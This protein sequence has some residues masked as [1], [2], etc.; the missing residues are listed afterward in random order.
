MTAT[1]VPTSALH[2]IKMT[3][4]VQVEV[5]GDIYWLHL[6]SREELDS[7]NWEALA[8]QW[9]A[10]KMK[11]D[12]NVAG[13][14][15]AAVVTTHF[16][17]THT[18][19]H[20]TVQSTLAAG[21]PAQEIPRDRVYGIAKDELEN[22]S[23]I[24]KGV[25]SHVGREGADLL[26]TH[27]DRDPSR[28]GLFTDSRS[29]E[30]TR[31]SAPAARSSLS[32]DAP[33]AESD[34][35]FHDIP[36]CIAASLATNDK[37]RS[38]QDIREFLSRQLKDLVSSNNEAE[39]SKLAKF[40]RDDNTLTPTRSRSD[41]TVLLNYAE[42]IVKEGTNPGDT[43][44][45]NLL[46]QFGKKHNPPLPSQI[47]VID[48]S[49][50]LK[51]E[52]IYEEGERRY[53]DPASALVLVQVDRQ[54]VLLP[55][56]DP[57]RHDLW[58]QD[59]LAVAC[60]RDVSIDNE[61]RLGC[62]KRMLRYDPA[63]IGKWLLQEMPITNDREH[64]HLVNLKNGLIAIDQSN[65]EAIIQQLEAVDKKNKQWLDNL[66]KGK[67]DSLLPRVRGVMRAPQP[68]PDSRS[69]SA[70][71]REIRLDRGREEPAEYVQPLVIPADL[72]DAEED[73]HSPLLSRRNSGDGTRHVHFDEPDAALT[74]DL[75]S[76]PRESAK[77]NRNRPDAY[78]GLSA[79]L[80]GEDSDSSRGRG[81][82]ASFSDSDDGSF[83]VKR[84]SPLARKESDAGS[85][86][87]GSGRLNFRNARKDDSSSDEEDSV[88][89][90]DES[91]AA[92]SAND[93]DSSSASSRAARREP[94]LEKKKNA[95]AAKG[96]GKKSAAKSG[97]KPAPATKT[98]TG[99]KRSV[100]RSRLSDI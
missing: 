66:C 34:P 18:V 42:H 16:S 15:G 36:G 57:K 91:D 43:A 40:I 49:F 93:S 27:R 95:S 32:L 62:V 53:L 7:R 83:A 89:S 92:S 19:E 81:R 9:A 45:L 35:R 2:A 21:T 87:D 6:A 85:E 97:K 12:T 96:K 74:A 11:L 22:I 77:K 24:F 80:R 73:D 70:S 31:P 47:V 3:D 79:S 41:T 23:R 26:G 51:N 17:A 82:R 84:G 76:V 30:E 14:K 72:S 50:N 10:L 46:V 5:N 56:E 39:I 99:A 37:R 25:K 100:P 71:S 4:H 60:D 61:Q 88:T 64:A 13:A 44:F 68:S 94:K 8:K 52:N 33:S 69:A 78:E 65:V 63:L 48:A 59:C 29:R 90:A 38:S 75:R 1:R 58:L 28:S 54:Y 86:S 98:K 67:Y 55:P 20:I